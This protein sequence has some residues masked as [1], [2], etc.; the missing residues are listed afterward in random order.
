MDVGAPTNH[1]MQTEISAGACRC[2][3]EKAPSLGVQTWA[4]I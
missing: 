3:S 2:S 1:F 4:L